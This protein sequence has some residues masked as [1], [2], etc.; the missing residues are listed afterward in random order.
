MT[1]SKWQWIDNTFG[2]MGWFSDAE[3]LAQ[4]DNPEFL[5]GVWR[6]ISPEEVEQTE[7]AIGRLAYEQ[8]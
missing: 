7:R 2:P 8:S 3:K 5:N 1:E 6:L 4:A